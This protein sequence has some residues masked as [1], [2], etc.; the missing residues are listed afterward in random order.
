MRCLVVRHALVVEATRIAVELVASLLIS[1]QGDEEGWHWNLVEH[2]P[3]W[4]ESKPRSE[5]RIRA[6]ISVDFI[7]WFKQN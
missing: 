5:C 7:I 2:R 6:G 3:L 4:E 1:R